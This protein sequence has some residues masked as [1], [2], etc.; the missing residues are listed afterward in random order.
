MGLGIASLSMLNTLAIAF[1]TSNLQGPFLCRWPNRMAVAGFSMVTKKASQTTAVLLVQAVKG[2]GCAGDLVHVKHSYAENVLLRQGLG[3]RADH[4][5][6][7]NMGFSTSADGEPLGPRQISRLITKSSGVEALLEIYR[8]HSHAFDEWHVGSFW[9]TLGKH[10]RGCSISE[11]HALALAPAREELMPT[12]TNFSARSLAN[13][14][15]G[16]ANSGLTRSGD[17]ALDWAAA[18]AELQVALL[19]N[20]HNA[21]SQELSMSAWASTVSRCY[22][23]VLYDALSSESCSRIG[24]FSAQDLS[25]VAWAFASA[26]HE[27]PVLFDAIARAAS[28]QLEF[29]RQGLS[30]LGWAFASAGHPAPA[31]LHN[32]AV[33]APDQLSSC[34]GSTLAQIAHSFATAGNTPPQ[35]FDQLAAEAQGRRLG[36]AELIKLAAAFARASHPAAR[37]MLKRVIKQVGACSDGG[38]T[39]CTPEQLALLAWACAFTGIDEAPL[40]SR[41]AVRMAE[42]MDEL[43]MQNLAKLAWAFAVADTLAE[44]LFGVASGF[45]ELC[46]QQQ[47]TAVELNQLH[48]WQIWA[49]NHTGWSPLS[50]EMQSLAYA[51][52][53][54][55]QRNP[56][57]MQ[58]E[59]ASSLRAFAEDTQ[60][61]VHTP[62]GWS[63]D[64]LCKHDGRE[65]AVEVDGPRHFIG[66]S[67]RPNGATLF[68]RRQLRACGHVLVT[69]P[70][71]EWGR[72]SKNGEEARQR[73]LQ[74]A[75]NAALG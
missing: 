39:Q 62:E 23:P 12:L 67:H 14:A 1:S 52:F 56:S 63:I 64:I 53:V 10:A 16:I 55:Q 26:G 45:S 38:L 73:Y 34:S 8:Q 9:H 33:T 75:L 42:K 29:S 31:L 27:A 36:V 24:E 3:R 44:E 51:S 25:V 57:R 32:A 58:K 66:R 28:G 22:D 60:E 69:V 7:K 6:L 15:H 18:F 17:A 35:L 59:V 61:E 48:Q 4:N 19:K 30:N 21:S 46:D 20:L 40:F 37:A 54:T 49:A 50:T 5:I 65:I 70:Y 41:I 68:K 2:L 71:W 13:I 74:E 11:A 47:W 72:A 43:S